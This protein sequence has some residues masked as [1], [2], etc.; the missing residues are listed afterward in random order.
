MNHNTK[1]VSISG[2]FVTRTDLPP[3]QGKQRIGIRIMPGSSGINIGGN[4]L[5][6]FDM[7][8]ECQSDKGIV[9]MANWCDPNVPKCGCS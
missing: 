8:F 2:A 5:K 3:V 4:N 1:G 9:T 6:G 7:P